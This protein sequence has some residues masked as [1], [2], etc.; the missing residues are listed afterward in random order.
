[1]LDGIK[2]VFFDLDHTLWDFEY[3]SK[4]SFNR[5]FSE[6][7]I[8][9]KVDDFLKVYQPINE[10]FWKD[11]R[12]DKV[13]KQDLRYGRLKE[14]FDALQM[15]VSDDQ[16]N[17]LSE[18]YIRVLGFQNKLFPDTNGVLTY[19]K[20]KGYGLHIITNG[21]EEVQWKKCVSSGIEGYFDKF[22][23]SESVGYKKPKPIVF[24]EALRRAGADANSSVMIGDNQEADIQGALN[25]GM[26]IIFC[27]FDQQINREDYLE[28]NSLIKIKELL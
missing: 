6:N 8:A 20:N 12:E 27:N 18:D 10:R 3:N 22:I 21:F 9:V 11:Y 1:M 5:I 25:V 28:V 13:S 26:K 16:I 19:L 24:E 23:S 7:D 15:S 14:S 2:D 17:Q 4:Q